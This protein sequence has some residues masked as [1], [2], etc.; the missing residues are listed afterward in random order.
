MP[1]ARKFVRDSNGVEVY[2][3]SF[4]KSSGQYY[5]IEEA[6]GKRVHHG[7]TLNAAIKSFKHVDA[8]LVADI[9]DLRK[10]I[11]QGAKTQLEA[12]L[13]WAPEESQ[14]QAALRSI[15][16]TPDAPPRH[17]LKNFPIVMRTGKNGLRL[18]INKKKIRNDIL[19][20]SS[21]PYA[22]Y[23]SINLRRTTSRRTDT[24]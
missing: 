3:L 9:A 5:S 12:A 22:T 6:T 18:R 23:L 4:H 15:T 19:I 8:A 16:T 7:T 17:Q 24:R 2:G 1:A 20:C 14:L 10:G 11:L 13:Q 21:K